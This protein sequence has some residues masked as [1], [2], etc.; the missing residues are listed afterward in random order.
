MGFQPSQLADDDFL[1]AYLGEFLDDD[2][3]DDLKKR[4][5]SVMAAK[6]AT[7]LPQEFGV[8]RGNFQV[9][10]ADFGLN[11]EQLQILHRLVESDA[12]R[13]TQEA[14]DIEQLGKTEFWGNL[15]RRILLL[16]LLG[17]AIFGIVYYVTPPKK[18]GFAP[19][20]TVPYE[21]LQMIVDPEGR[22]NFPTTIDQDIDDFMRNAKDLGF[23]PKTVKSAP[24]LGWGVEGASVIDYDLAKVVVVQ[25]ANQK[26]GQK[27]FVFQYEGKADDLPKSDPGNHKG[28]LYHAY[29]S[30]QLNMIVW[31]AK[32][33]VVAMV[34][35]SQSA[36]D[37]AALAFEAVGI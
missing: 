22:L 16:V 1:Y 2:L 37:L 8:A 26:L 36:Q 34:V 21:A 7:H 30:D 12:Q 25:L 24:L 9:A 32:D 5:D 29:K 19:L 13:A 33:D 11:E 23:T 28:L 3:E 35:G 6:N 14:S 17:G 15:G 18:A 20:D 27:A 31:Q 10:I 4:Y